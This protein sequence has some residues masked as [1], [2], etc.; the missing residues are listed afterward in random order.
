[1]NAA[2]RGML[3]MALLAPAACGDGSPP[4]ADAIRVERG[5]LALEIDGDPN[6][7]LWDGLAQKL[8]VADD[9]GN[10]ILE[11]SDERGLVTFVPLP[12]A[13]PEGAGLGQLV[14]DADGSLVVTRFG[15]GT[16]GGVAVVRVGGSVVDVPGL[17]VT[18][19]RTGLT[20]AT[21]GMLYDAWFVH[22]DAGE[23]RGAV[24]ELSLDGSEREVIEGLVKPIG[25][26]A[27]GERLFVSDQE[28]GEIWV[29]PRVDPA[30]HQVFASVE[31][32]D[33]LS[34]GPDGSLFSGSATGNVFHIDAAGGVSTFQSGFREVR[35]VAYDGGERRLF[36]AEHDP[37]EDGDARHALHILPVD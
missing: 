6:G 24:A 7:L 37:S 27:V 22:E 8:Y 17:D 11:W 28:L 35:G 29:A 14:R 9:A 13:P 31:R 10:R 15:F 23:P 21:D 5:P 30:S 20:R 36:V 4:V 26:L 34:A 12:E 1:M 3:G 2:A 19:R 16:R 18:R 25:V 33:L 32:P